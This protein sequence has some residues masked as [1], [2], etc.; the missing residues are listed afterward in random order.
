MQY[1]VNVQTVAQAVI[2]YL[3]TIP[4]QITKPMHYY[5]N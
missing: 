3:A 4:V 1:I 2:W 5:E